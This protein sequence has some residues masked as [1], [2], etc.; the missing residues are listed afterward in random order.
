VEVYMQKPQYGRLLTDGGNEFADDNAIVLTG[1]HKSSSI[2][3]STQWLHPEM[4][5]IVLKRFILRAHHEKITMLDSWRAGN[6]LTP[7]L[8]S[9]Q[10]ELLKT[11]STVKVIARPEESIRVDEMHLNVIHRA[12]AK[13]R[14][15]NT[16]RSALTCKAGAAPY[17]SERIL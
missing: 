7:M 12:G 8:R 10:E 14:V 9:A 13:I 5:G 15:G 1:H 4:L 6:S 11:G 16:D 17:S 3:L 2:K